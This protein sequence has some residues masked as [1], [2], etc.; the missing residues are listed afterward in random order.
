MRTSSAV[1][2]VSALS[3]SA[4]QMANF[5]A[6]RIPTEYSLKKLKKEGTH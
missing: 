3:T 6:N 4:I 2:N 1:L 5:V